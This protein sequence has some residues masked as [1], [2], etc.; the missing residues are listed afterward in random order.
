MKYGHASIDNGYGLNGTYATHIVL[1]PGT[2]ITT[3]PDGLT[4]DVWSP[5]NCALATVANSLDVQRLPRYGANNSAV[6]QGAGLLGIY[7]VAWLKHH[8]GMEK[9]FCLDVNPM[10][11]NTAKKFGA[12][13]LLI[14]PN[15]PRGAEERLETISLLAPHGVDVVVEM[16]GAKQVLTEGINLLRNGGHYAF[17]GMVH[18]DSF[19]TQISGEQIVRKCLTIRGTHNYTPWNL[20]ES[21]RFLAD[22]TH[23]PW[24][25]VLSEERYPLRELDSAFAAALSGSACRVVVDC[26]A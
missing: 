6:V 24:N 9:V 17:C 21:V 5:V 16:T 18:P 11:L 10:R 23:L 14:D 22:N 19:L 8:I 12:E 2:H 20:E 1:R 7:A 26:Q 13:T 15:N 25:A 3:L 4:A